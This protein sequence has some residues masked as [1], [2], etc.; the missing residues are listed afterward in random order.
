MNE[1]VI[2]CEGPWSKDS[3]TSLRVKSFWKNVNYRGVFLLCQHL[4]I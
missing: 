4:I 3:S 2:E 1:L